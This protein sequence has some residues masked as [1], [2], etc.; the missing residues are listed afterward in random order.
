M[1]A[2]YSHTT[3]T[4]GT[5]LTASIYNTDHQNHIDNGVPLQQ[6]DYSSNATQMQSTT[7]PGEVG[8]ESLATTQAGEFERLRFILKEL[9]GSDQWYQSAPS[10]A[11]ESLIIADR[12]FA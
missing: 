8:S 5:T 12:V 11:S 9:T 6:D 10:G 1:A 4:T 3:R 7:D 2:L